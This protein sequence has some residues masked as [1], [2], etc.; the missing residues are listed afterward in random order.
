MINN[1]PGIS[2][3]LPTL[4]EGKNLAI[5]IP[6][7]TRM[8]SDLKY[9]IYEILVMDDGSN[10][11]TEDILIDLNRDNERVKLIKRKNE[12][13]L[14]MAIFDGVEVSKF[15]YVM[16]LDADGSMPVETIELL[17]K[18]IETKPNSV[19]IGSRFV[20]GGGY[21][22]VKDLGRFSF[23]KAVKNVNKSKDSVSGMIL[24]IL[25]NKLLNFVFGFQIKDITSGFIIL[26]KK[27]I[28]KKSFERTAYGEYFIYLINDLLKRKIDI[29]EVGYICK[30]RIHGES[31]TASS[32]SQLIKRGIPYIIAARISKKERNENI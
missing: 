31:K 28:S 30:T 25:F 6:E 15:E 24:S 27:Y 21:K 20:Q 29:V 10:D 32:I 18:K 4:N 16:W 12:P 22:G 9:E 8:F 11:S 13:S 23:F 17:I 7:I 1:I 19:I 14:P 3:I 2:I 5:L 26:P